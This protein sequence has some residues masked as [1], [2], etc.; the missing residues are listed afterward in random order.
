MRQ[1]WEG[2]CRVGWGGGSGSERAWASPGAAGTA[3]WPVASFGKGAPLSL[4][5]FPGG[6]AGPALAHLEPE[7]SPQEGRR[8]TPSWGLELAPPPPADWAG[9]P[10]TQE[11]KASLTRSCVQALSIS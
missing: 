5:T 3:L 11:R 9:T 2:A 7:G 1:G 10:A 4:L 6:G 8:G